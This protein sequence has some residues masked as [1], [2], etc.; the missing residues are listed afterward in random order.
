ML[1]MIC[2]GINAGDGW[3][4]K[5]GNMQEDTPWMK[6]KGDF[7]AT[8]FIVNEK[9][10]FKVWNKPSKSVNIDIVEKIHKGDEVIFPIVFSGCGTGKDGK[11]KLKGSTLVLAPDGKEYTKVNN[12]SLFDNKPQPNLA[13]NVSQEYIK[14]I[15][16]PSDKLGTYKVKVRV[17]DLV[18]KIDINL[19]RSFQVVDKNVSIETK[20]DNSQSKPVEKIEPNKRDIEVGKWMTYAYKED[21]KKDMESIKYMINSK[22]FT[23]KRSTIF[24]IAIF[25]SKRFKQDD[26]Y[27]NSIDIN[28]D[29]LNNK[30]LF[31]L[32]VALK[33]ADTQKSKALYN[34][35]LEKTNDKQLL[36][37][38]HSLPVLDFLTIDINSPAVLDMLWASFMATGDTL[39]V[40]RIIDVLGRKDSKESINY[41]LIKSSAKWSILS[42][43]KQHTKVLEVCKKYANSSNVTLRKEMTEIVEK[44]YERSSKIA[45]ELSD[46]N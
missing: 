2:V 15:I 29:S 30:S 8:L 5:E 3:K 35:L 14:V 9:E 38:I 17:R 21:N 42:N 41:L 34:T 40:E 11:C 32:L 36:N 44:V 16:E 25:I 4:D 22:A 12:M 28:F 24:P 18:K 27:L 37:Y 43:A 39:Y 6:S 31:M 20:K 26:E 19:Q 46:G 23:Q 1:I 10:F 45:K 33:Q 7:G 13:L